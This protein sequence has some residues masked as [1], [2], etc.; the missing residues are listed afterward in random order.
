MKPRAREVLRGRLASAGASSGLLATALACLASASCST[1]GDASRPEA[2]R[3]VVPVAVAASMREPFEE[4]AAEFMAT[5]PHADVRASYLSSGA[6][7][8]QILAGAPFKLFVSADTAYPAS[9]QRAGR[10]VPGS[11]LVYARGSLA[12][13]LPNRLAGEV[14]TRRG[15]ED[16]TLPSRAAAPAHPNAHGGNPIPASVRRIVIASPALAPY[17]RAASEVLAA[18]GASGIRAVHGDDAAQASQ[19][20]LAG[21]DAALLPMS[22]ATLSAMREAGAIVPL[23]ER[24]HQPVLHAAVALEGAGENA[25]A[26]LRFLASDHAQAILARY[27]FR[28]P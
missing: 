25:T 28:A 27:G 24:M 1:A 3:V 4:I 26:L 18:L 15:T 23:A 7:V 20:A 19:I 2:P 8:H 11:L 16:D 9:L 10:T 5:H 14:E 21:A 6:A 17:G 13:W 12:L 22:L